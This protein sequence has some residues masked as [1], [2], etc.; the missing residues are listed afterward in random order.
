MDTKEP[1]FSHLGPGGEAAMVNVGGK[2][3]TRRRAVAEGWIRM[4]ASTLERIEARR[5]RKGDVLA[6]AR[7]AAVGGA[8]RAAELIPLCH[9]LPIDGIE[10]EIELRPERPGVRLQVAV[11]AEARTGVEMEALCGVAAGLL[12]T[13]DMCKSVERGMTIEAIELVSKE[14]GASGAWRREPRNRPGM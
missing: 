4:D 10:V 2:A 12:A 13:Y 3:V 6:V 5:I 11:N 8:K 7:I 9:P 1:S 14:G